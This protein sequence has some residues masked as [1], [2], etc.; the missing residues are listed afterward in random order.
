MTLR[1]GLMWLLIAV[2]VALP[3][4]YDPMI[5]LKRWLIKGAQRSRSVAP[6]PPLGNDEREEHG[7]RGPHP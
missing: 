4:R 2:L 3:A 1:E 5:R 6:T 7:K